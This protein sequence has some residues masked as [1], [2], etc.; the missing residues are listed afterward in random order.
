MH[1]TRGIKAHNEMVAFTVA[2]LVLGGDLGQAEGTPVGEA[3]DNAT[4]A[5]NL[6]TSIP[7]DPIRKN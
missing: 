3:A 5:D 6:G 7:G 4:A 2:R 1:G